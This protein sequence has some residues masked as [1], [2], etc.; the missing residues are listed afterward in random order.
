MQINKIFNK[1]NILFF[2]SRRD[3]RSRPFSAQ[4]L[5]LINI[6]TTTF[7]R[8]LMMGSIMRFI[9]FNIIAGK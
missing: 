1:K 9:C 5:E 2:T 8:R 7:F 6:P 4:K 3:R